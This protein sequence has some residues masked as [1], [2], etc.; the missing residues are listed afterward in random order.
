MYYMYLVYVLYLK[1][2][3]FQIMSFQI[4]GIQNISNKI[5][6]LCVFYKYFVYFYFFLQVEDDDDD[7]DDDL[8]DDLDDD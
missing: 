4:S 7:E 5:Y 1:Q 2:K 6:Y 8:D 3:C